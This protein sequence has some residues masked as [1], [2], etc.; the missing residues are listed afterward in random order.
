MFKNKTTLSNQHTC[1]SK[2]P[3]TTSCMGVFYVQVCRESLAYKFQT[4]LYSFVRIKSYVFVKFS[5]IIKSCRQPNTTSH[6]N[7]FT[8]WPVARFI[9]QTDCLL[10]SFRKTSEYCYF[11]GRMP[12]LTQL[13]KH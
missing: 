5:K 7:L 10:W 1:S 13:L 3:I 9:S 11:R 2:D 6:I 12:F 8:S 4:Q